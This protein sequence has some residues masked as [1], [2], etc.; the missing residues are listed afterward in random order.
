MWMR[1]LSVAGVA[2]ALL[3][4]DAANA[5]DGTRGYLQPGAFEVLPVLLHAPLKAD[6]R[7]EAD[8]KIFLTTRKLIGTP[9]WQMATNDVKSTP[10]DMLRDF[11]CAVGVDM[12]PE[13]APHVAALIERAG[14][15]T[16]RGTN[17][18]K[19]HYQRLRPFQIDEGQTCQPKEQV[20]HNFDY[21]S[22]HTTRGWT[23][24]QILAELAPDRAT[25]ILA[26]GRAYGESRIVCGVHNASAVEAGRLSAMS[27]L[28]VVRTTAAYRADFAAA[29]AEL[30]VL[31]KSPTATRPPHCAVEARLVSQDIYHPAASQP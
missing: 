18:A 16:G 4:A 30:T 3:V 24:A 19:R 6:A 10:A 21:P 22:G 23:W 8:R 15:D 5:Q 11:S 7:Y 20:A 9:R 12:T 2:A 26:R 25:Q 1:S 13:N 31:R 28:A 17:I 27:T 29:S 14:T